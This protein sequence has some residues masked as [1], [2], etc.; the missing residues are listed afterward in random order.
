MT[1]YAVE[2]RPPNAEGL[3]KQGM[4][5]DATFWNSGP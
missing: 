2:V 4:P 5:A 3:L 1:F